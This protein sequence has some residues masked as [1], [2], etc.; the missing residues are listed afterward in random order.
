MKFSYLSGVVSLDY[1]S[2]K[3]IGCGRCIEVCPHGVFKIK[4][5]KAII[6]ARDYCMEC[7]ACALN[8]VSGALTVNKGV[9]C[10]SAMINGL[11]TKGNAD[12]G[13]CDCGGESDGCC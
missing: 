1:S 8:C 6:V 9:G 4:D 5:H 13:S 11:M 2:E 7:G 12:L 3:C 10:A